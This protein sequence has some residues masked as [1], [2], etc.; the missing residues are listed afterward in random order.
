MFHCSFQHIRWIIVDVSLG[1]LT[2]RPFL[3]FLLHLFI[4]LF[5]IPVPVN[6]VGASFLVKTSD[7]PVHPLSTGKFFQEAGLPAKPII[8]LSATLCIYN[9]QKNCRDLEKFSFQISLVCQSDN[10]SSC[11]VNRKKVNVINT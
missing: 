3:P 6:T 9:E 10:V 1:G 8:E 7:P 4:Y 11:V 2:F 5:K